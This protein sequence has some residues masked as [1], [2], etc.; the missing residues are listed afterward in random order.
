MWNDAEVCSCD[1][2]FNF[3]TKAIEKS[4]ERRQNLLIHTQTHTQKKI[5]INI[6]NSLEQ[7]KRIENLSVAHFHSICLIF[8]VM[9]A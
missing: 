8:C 6:V 7:K 3:S 2:Y 1:A 5:N 4:H 9:A